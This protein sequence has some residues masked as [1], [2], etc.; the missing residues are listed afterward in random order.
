[1]AVQKGID[2][3]FLKLFPLTPRKGDLRKGEIIQAAI[4]SIGK[5]GIENLS[6]ESIGA[7][8][9]IN[10]AHV[11]Y[12]FKKKDEIVESAIKYITF[13][14]NELTVQEILK[15]KDDVSRIEGVVI[16]AF[17]WIEQNP[18]QGST[19]LAFYHLCGHN[20]TFKKLHTQI[21]IA[22]AERLSSLLA[23]I[24]KGASEE[25]I[26]L[27]GETI[28]AIITNNILEYLTAEKTISYDK[29]LQRTLDQ[30]HFIIN[31]MK[32]NKKIN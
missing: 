21:R 12:Y 25:D 2:P 24:A 10:R 3:I 22:G 30:I 23:K 6:Y 18:N 26:Q 14:A 1:M 20:K 27:S 32:R 31:L 29:T 13:V 8:L 15:A 9:N 17:K 19:M 7:K 5:D 11:A 4:E 16:A 28:Q